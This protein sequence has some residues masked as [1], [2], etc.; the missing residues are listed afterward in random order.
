[1]GLEI[2]YIVGVVIFGAGLAWATFRYRQRSLAQ[3]LAGDA[4]T[5]RLFEQPDR[6]L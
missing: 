6:S 5:R 4:A 2:I 3:K 1:M